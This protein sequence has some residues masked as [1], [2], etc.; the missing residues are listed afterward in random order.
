MPKVSAAAA[1]AAACA[2]ALSIGL[3]ATGCSGRSAPVEIPARSD[4]PRTLPHPTANDAARWADTVIPD[5]A[6]GGTSWSQR[7]AGVLEPGR[8]PVIT[9]P[10]E[11]APAIV[12][13]ACVSG[14]GGELAYTVTADDSTLDTGEIPCASVDGTAEPRSIR[15]VPA[16]ATVE[17]TAGDTGLYVYAVSPDAAT[18]R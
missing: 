3:L 1:C 5:N 17:L 4:D 14:A 15:G 11:Q 7:Q 9:V 16:D 12:T 13:I 10:A 2:A 18:D 8:E 6:I